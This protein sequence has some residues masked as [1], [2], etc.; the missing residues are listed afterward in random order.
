[1]TLMFDQMVVAGV[2]LIGGSLALAAKNEG[3]VSRVVGFGRTKAP[4]QLARRKKIIDAYF[5]DPEEFPPATDLVVPR[6]R[7]N[8]RAGRRS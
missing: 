2:G 8:W 7:C 3:L 1:M 6:H 4:L 5:L